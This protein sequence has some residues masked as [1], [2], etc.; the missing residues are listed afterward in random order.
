MDDGH[1]WFREEVQP[2]GAQLQHY[3]KGSFPAVR[4]VDDVVQESYLRIW[5]AKARQPIQSAKAFL[6]SIARHVALDVLRKSSRSPIQTLSDLDALGVLEERPANPAAE[7]ARFEA[8]MR[9]LAAA[10]ARLPARQR[11]I[12]LLR[13]FDR[14]SQKEVADR[15]QLSERTVENHLHRAIKACEAYVRAQGI[16][17]FYADDAR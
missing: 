17:D 14:I 13:K 7:S 8:K 4:D 1:R 9:L 10:I 16:D 5:K 3:L 12:V 2:H 6:F 11:E 15:L